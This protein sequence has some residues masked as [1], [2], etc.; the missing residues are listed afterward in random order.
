MIPTIWCLQSYFF[1]ERACDDYLLSHSVFYERLTCLKCGRSMERNVVRMT[2]RCP[3]KRCRTEFSLRKHTFFFGS[4]LKNNQILYLGYLWLVGTSR[5]SA[6]VSTGFSPNT[7]TAFYMHFRSL[8][9]SMLSEE[10]EVIGGPNVTVEVDETK[11][12]KRKYNRGHR[13]EGVWVVA[14]VERTE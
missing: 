4:M 1:D 12:G 7:V 13:V 14:G 6:L 9:A 10:D 5:Q 2:Y 11:L 8:V 3:A